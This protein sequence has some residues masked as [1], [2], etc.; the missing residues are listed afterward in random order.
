MW[1]YCECEKLATPASSNMFKRFKYKK[2]DSILFEMLQI[3]NKKAAAKLQN[4]ST[5]LFKSGG[6]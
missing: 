2:K 1:K 5:R 4:S 6:F 3:T